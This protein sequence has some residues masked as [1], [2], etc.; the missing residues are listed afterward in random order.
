LT[1]PAAAALCSSQRSLVQVNSAADST[2]AGEA[3]NSRR[4]QD[5]FLSQYCPL[6]VLGLY[7]GESNLNNIHAAFAKKKAEAKGNKYKTTQL[8]RAYAILT[9]P[10]SSYYEKASWQQGHRQ[11]LLVDLLPQQQRRQVKGYM[12]TW[13]A[14]AVLGVLAMVYALLHPIVRIHRAA[15]R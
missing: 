8:E 3:N 13:S 9:D 5:S 11:K 12:Y 1:A 2:G 6:E 10:R 14:V 4:D 15:T 7:E